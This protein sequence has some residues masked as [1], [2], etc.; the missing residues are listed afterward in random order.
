[1]KT[2]YWIVALALLLAVCVGLSLLTF[3]GEAASRARITSKGKEVRTVDL[4]F[5][6]EFTVQTEDGYNVVTVK[7]GKIAVTEASCPDHHCM[8]RGF[9]NSGAQIVC[10][11]NKLVIEFLGDAEVDGIVG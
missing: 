10:L 9:C 6:Q 8:A 3:G 11:P 5:D 1:M 2:K 4:S 7:D